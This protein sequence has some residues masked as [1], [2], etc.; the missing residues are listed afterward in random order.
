M[1]SKTSSVWFKT[2]TKSLVQQNRY[3]LRTPQFRKCTYEHTLY[4]KD[5]KDG[6]LVI[7]LYV[8]DL[9]IAS[10]SMKLISEFKDEM[11]KEFE[12]TDM[13]K[14]HYFLGMEVSYEDGNIILSQKKY[15]KNLLEK[16]RMSQCNTVSTPM[17][18]GIKLSKDDPEEFI[19][20]SMYRSLVGSLMYLT[21]TR[22]DI[23]FAVSKISRFME[24]PKRSHWEAAKRILKYVKG[25]LDQGITYSKGGKQKLIGFSNSDYAG[26]VDDSKSTSGYIFHLGSGPISWQSKKQKVVALSSTEA[27]YMALTLAGCQAIWLKGILDEL[28]GKDNYP[29][30]IYCDNKSTIC[31]AKDSVYHGKS[32]HI[33]VKYHFIRDLIRREDVTI[34]F[35][36]TKDQLADIM[37][38]ALQPKD[39]LRAKL[40]VMDYLPAYLD[41]SLQNE[42]MIRGVSFASGASGFD[43]LTGRLLANMSPNSNILEWYYRS[44]EDLIDLTH[45]LNRRCWCRKTLGETLG[46]VAQK[47]SERPPGFEKKN[48]RKNSLAVVGYVMPTGQ[49]LKHFMS[50]SRRSHLMSFVHRNFRLEN[51]V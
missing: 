50:H 41:P 9:I 26:N 36:A 38:K 15:M 30:P 31:L 2:G 40:G 43:P 33:R 21:N 34:L 24:A 49:S 19:N 22:P 51:Y 11:K 29:I 28:Q 47:V 7:C 42:D 39:F 6:K 23:M 44:H 25:T 5:T 8:D 37:T 1:S 27:E 3:V 17:D 32:K 4:I 14:L 48:I 10:N 18:Y 45:D 20:E 35:C 16:Y 46:H 12:M 13:G